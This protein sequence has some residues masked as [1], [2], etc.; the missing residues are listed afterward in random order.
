MT[1][2]PT[3]SVI[4][5]S[6]NCA[7]YIGQAIESVLGQ[8]FGDFELLISDDGSTDGSPELIADYARKDARIVAFFQ[9]QNLGLVR[10]YNFLFGKAKGSLIVIQDADDWSDQ[11]RFEKQVSAMA[12]PDFVLCA[13]GHIF[14]Y[15]SGKTVST[16]QPSQVIDGLKTEFPSIPASTMFRAEML[17]QYQGWQEYFAGGTPMD[18]YFLMDLLDGRQGFHIADALYHARIR[19]GSNCRVWNE[20][21]MTSYQLYL[22]LAEQRRKTGTD[23]LREG[24]LTEMKRFEVAAGRDR[25]LRA[26]S[27]RDT[28]AI[29]I[30]CDN[31]GAAAKLLTKS[32]VLNPTSSLAWRSAFYLVR[33]ILR[34]PRAS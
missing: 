28:A 29:N 15:P 21:M 1:S 34:G 24:K 31:Y 2:T 7:P 32:L 9:P 8:T 5:T 20:R 16:N 25:R 6:Y 12:N 22:E 10:N 18:R 3:V 11:H 19:S 14:H 13:T 30:D 4:L 27:M 33:K 26:Q 23:W 17:R